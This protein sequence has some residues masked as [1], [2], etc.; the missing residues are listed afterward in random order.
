MR[1]MRCTHPDDAS[2]GVDMERDLFDVRRV[3]LR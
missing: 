1:A 3:Q 2:K